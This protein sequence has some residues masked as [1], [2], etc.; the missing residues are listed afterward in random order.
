MGPN[1]AGSLMPNMGGGGGPVGVPPL[2]GPGGQ[3]PPPPGPGPMMGPGGINFNSPSVQHALDNLMAGQPHMMTQ[4]G[5][6]P[7]GGGGGG[8]GG[9]VPLMQAP[10]VPPMSLLGEPPMGQG[11]GMFPPGPDMFAPPRGGRR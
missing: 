2:S 6:G 8:G 9:V 7:R 11:Q 1:G 5:P 3:W 4:G 10:M